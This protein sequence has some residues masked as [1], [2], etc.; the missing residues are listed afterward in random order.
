MFTGYTI[1]VTG[2]IGAGKS[3]QCELLLR[4]LGDGCV[5]VPEFLDDPDTERAKA[6]KRMLKDWIEGKETFLD[7]QRFISDSQDL[8]LSRI[9]SDYSSRSEA[10]AGSGPGSSCVRVRVME[11]IPSDGLIFALA[12]EGKE[13]PHYQQVREWSRA[14]EE[15]HNIRHDVRYSVIDSLL[16]AK[17]IHDQIMGIAKE[18]LEALSTG[19]PITRVIRLAP[20]PDVCIQ[21]VLDR[22]RPE[23]REYTREYLLKIVSLYERHREICAV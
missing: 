16:G 3:T 20:T 2:P 23:E 4:S 14:V 12:S 6:A 21:R 17:D 13:G 18:D 11:R 7:F 8:I 9:E 10:G 1:V 15:K 5:M 22:N 19:T